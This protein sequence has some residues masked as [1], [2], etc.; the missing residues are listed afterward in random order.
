MNC[1]AI[2]SIHKHTHIAIRCKYSNSSEFKGKIK[3][4]NNS[5]AE[6]DIKFIEIAEL[7]TKSDLTLRFLKNFVTC[8]TIL[9]N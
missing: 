1:S 6:F 8:S 7:F 2:K 9:I 3:I 5:G 4:G